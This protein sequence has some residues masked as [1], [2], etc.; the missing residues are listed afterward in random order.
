MYELVWFNGTAMVMLCF[1]ST[2]GVN[3]LDFLVLR[4]A[5]VLCF[6]IQYCII[7]SIVKADLL[8]DSIMHLLLWSVWPCIGIV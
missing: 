6:W 8:L 2:N 3:E 7:V 4:L 5:L 1:V